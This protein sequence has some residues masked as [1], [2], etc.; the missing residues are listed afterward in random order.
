VQDEWNATVLECYE[1][2]KLLEQT[3]QE[4]SHTLYQH[5]AACRVIRF[6]V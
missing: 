6:R 1:L 3:R 2:R 4:L 5:D